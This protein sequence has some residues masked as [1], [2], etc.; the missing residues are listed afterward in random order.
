MSQIPNRTGVKFTVTQE[1]TM[2]KKGALFTLSH[3]PQTTKT[4]S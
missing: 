1:V 2:Y 3:L 4:L